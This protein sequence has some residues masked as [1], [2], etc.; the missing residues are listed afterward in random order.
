MGSHRIR[1]S[2]LISAAA[3]AAV[4][5]GARAGT[6]AA[7]NTQQS[8]FSDGTPEL[9]SD[10]EVTLSTLRTLGVTTLRAFVP[11][12]SIAPRSSSRKPPKGFLASDPA[13]YPKGAWK[14]FDVLVRVAKADGIQLLMEPTSPAPM[15]AVGRAPRGIGSHNPA[16]WMP[17]AQEFGKFVRA[18]GARYSGS[19]DPRVHA[20]RPGN[21]NDLPRIS[22][23]SV[24]NEPNFG[25]DLTPQARHGIEVSA[26]EYRSLVDQ[27]RNGL[28]ASGHGDDTILFGEL[29]AR[30][31]VVPGIA[32]STD[33]LRF[34]RAMYC[35]DSSYR[36]LRG[37]AALVRHCPA[38]AAKSRLFVKNNPA[39]FQASGYAA[40]PY[41]VG[42]TGPPNIPSTSEHP[43]WAG[44]ADM[45]RLIRTLD[46]LT[47]IYHSR[48]HFPVYITE[49]A[50]QTSP[51]KLNCRCSSP[52]TAAYYMNWAEYLSWRN[53]RVASYAQYQLADLPRREVPVHGR[54]SFWASGLIAPGGL[55]EPA[56][57]A[58][59]LPLYM[60]KTLT[61]RGRALS[62]WGDVRP[63]SYAA[64]DSDAPQR[65]Q[66]QFRLRSRG[67]W[68]TLRTVKITNRR[69][70]F[71][72][73]LVF[74]QS[75][76]V[77]LRWSYPLGFTGNAARYPDA[78]VSRTQTITVR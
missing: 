4:G 76:S 71:D 8:I 70:Y 15:W 49:L 36:P 46:R 20:N 60:P 35:V 72:V 63:A 52:A 16:T 57:D 61:V 41:T 5:G 21:T 45:P 50:F 7:S 23:W 65:A 9:L 56:Y 66:I 26:P 75:G 55:P 14:P 12:A 47:A 13:A 28:R 11:W 77:R 3:A 10:P 68:T 29:A 48:H 69:G 38:T 17:S 18:L 64:A 73:R 43:D 58:F 30:G 27:T 19:Y 67:A 62:V 39:L 53:P 24:W 34:L 51:P 6:A 1:R 2:L 37:E 59:R 54:Y 42:E 32:N 74:P 40:H 31:S 33:P 78:I 22:F 25:P 44:F